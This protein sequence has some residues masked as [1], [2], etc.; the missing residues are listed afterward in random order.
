MRYDPDGPSETDPVPPSPAHPAAWTR[1]GWLLGAPA[2]LLV[3][4]GSAW[5]AGQRIA[6]AVIRSA[7]PAIRAS[8]EGV[9]EPWLRLDARGRD[10]V[11]LGEAPGEG[12][13][14]AVLARLASTPGLRRVVDRVGLVET[15]SPFL[16]TAERA[17]A[18]RFDLTGH[19]PAEMG[20]AALSRVLVADLPPEFGLHDRARAA[21][22]AP[23]DFASGAA[24][25]IARLRGLAPGG[26]ATLSD[27]V[28]SLRGEA[29]SVPAYEAVRAA[30]AAPPQGYSLGAIE[31]LPPQVDDFRFAIGRRGGKVRL[32]GYAV[33]EAARERIR[34][35][36]AEAAEGA[37]VEDDLAIARGLP[38]EVDPDAIVRLMLRAAALLQDGTVSIEGDR[39][40]VTGGAIDAQAV[41]DLVDLVRRERPAG[42]REGGVSVVAVP[43][44]PYRLRVRRDADSV[45]LSGHVPDQ[46]AR[47]ALLAALRPR[48][49]REAVVDRSRLAGGAPPD[50]VAAVVAGVDPLATLASGELAVTDRALRLSGESLYAQSAR[51]LEDGLPRAL[52]AGWSARVDVGV[53]GAEA[54]GDAQTC[55]RLFAD[56][57]AEG[58]LRFAPGSAD[59]RPGF[60]PLLDALAAAARTCPTREIDVVGHADAPGAARP[61]PE[62]AGE[63]RPAATGAVSP[64]AGPGTPSPNRPGGKTDEK[65]SVSNAKAGKDAAAKDA[66]IAPPKPDA[67]PPEPSPADLA[68]ARA[69]AIVDYLQK[70]GVPPDHA[71]VLTGAAPQTERQGVGFV[72][73]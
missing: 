59:L 4:A 40:S 27:T 21:R 47:D 29:A 52:P 30:L 44:S 61:A 71:V 55:A 6:D 18:D 11:A 24:F 46:A 51:S 35:G 69:A 9:P 68:R 37:A 2:L 50:L 33:S 22:G 41:G 60:Y 1:A 70:A 73:R 38:P 32:A 72:V 45:T 36:A 56:R 42:I 28:L 54:L 48:F 34:A 14:A 53:R 63:A 13:R 43:V 64:P 31:I 58:S 16:W 26:T 20:A 10:V 3:W 62:P 67:K 7:A 49:F 57:I 39:L 23:P 8:E 19:R 5:F 66:R 25:A 65:P 12:E 15:A 17:G